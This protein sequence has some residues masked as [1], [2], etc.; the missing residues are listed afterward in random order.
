MTET[1]FEKAFQKAKEIQSFRFTR[2]ELEETARVMDG[3]YKDGAYI[4]AN[5]YQAAYNINYHCM[6]M[7]GDYPE[8]ALLK[9]KR[10]YMNNVNLIEKKE[11]IREIYDDIF[12]ENGSL[13]I[14]KRYALNKLSKEVIG[15]ASENDNSYIWKEED[16]SVVMF[17]ISEEF[18]VSFDE[19][20]AGLSHH[21]DFLLNNLNLKDSQIIEAFIRNSENF[22]EEIDEY[23]LITTKRRIMSTIMD[24]FLNDVASEEEGVILLISALVEENDEDFYKLMK[25][26]ET[27][28]FSRQE[29]VNWWGTRHYSST[30]TES[31]C[32]NNMNEIFAQLELQG[33]YETIN[34]ILS[35]DEEAFNLIKP[36]FSYLS[37]D[38]AIRFEDFEMLYLDKH[39]GLKYL[40]SRNGVK[41]LNDEEDVEEIY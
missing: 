40:L 29:F 21:W 15:L 14:L 25:K 4:E 38:F 9:L 12:I 2:K 1:E 19:I 33:R 5:I 18:D 3:F 10:V 41:L 24:T 31:S 7:E 30:V 35:G 32:V 16:A 37:Q 11:N 13:R 27:I 34:A 23:M 6:D 36:E 28:G 8:K 17:E 22:E 39:H 20:V 26:F